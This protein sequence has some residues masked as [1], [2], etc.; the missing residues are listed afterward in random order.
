MLPCVFYL[1]NQTVVSDLDPIPFVDF[2]ECVYVLYLWDHVVRVLSNLMVCAN[3]DPSHVD[4]A[5]WHI[6]A[7]RQYHVIVLDGPRYVILCISSI[8]QYGYTLCF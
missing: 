8:K 4:V 2:L 7:R 3:F 6:Q 5:S 1:P